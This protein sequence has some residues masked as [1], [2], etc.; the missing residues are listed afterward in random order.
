MQSVVH[1]Y[2]IFHLFYT[3]T[4]TLT[5]SIVGQACPEEE[6]TYT[7]VVDQGATLG[8]TAAPVLTNPTAVVFVAAAP[9]N[10]TRL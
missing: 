2:Y 1:S 6:V 5:S 8:W 3:A 7:C 4:I 10:N 9:S